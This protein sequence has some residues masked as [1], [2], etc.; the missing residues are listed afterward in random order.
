MNT[1]RRFASS[2]IENIHHE[3]W[4]LAADTKSESY[5]NIEQEKHKEL[6]IR[7]SYAV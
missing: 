3:K 7:E 5:D 1:E 2:N 4:Y 6:S